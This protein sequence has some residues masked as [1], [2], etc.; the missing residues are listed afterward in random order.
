MHQRS[1]V[2]DGRFLP[3]SSE[4]T[5]QWPGLVSR[6]CCLYTPSPNTKIVYG[7]KGPLN[8][9]RMVPL[10]HHKTESSSAGK[11]IG[12]EA[13]NVPMDVDTMVQ[14]L[15]RQLDDDQALNVNIKNM[16][17]KSTYQSSVVKTPII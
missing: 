6:R 16:I 2:G 5:N 17:H 12:C 15:P 4:I 9:N 10:K 14:Q 13:I 8:T 3:T 7:R 11:Y 1:S